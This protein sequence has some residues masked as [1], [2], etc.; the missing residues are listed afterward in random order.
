MFIWWAEDDV[1]A[2]PARFNCELLLVVSSE[3]ATGCGR[4]RV[5]MALIAVQAVRMFLEIQCIPSTVFLEIQCIPGTVFLEIQCIPGRVF[6]EIQCIPGTVFLEIQC[7][8][9]AVFL[10]IQCIP[11]AIFLEIQCIPGVADGGSSG[12]FSRLV[13]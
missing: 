6:L 12:A 10:E 8:P 4:S 11:G 1:E 3:F 9:G 2:W 7:I 13:E 5:K